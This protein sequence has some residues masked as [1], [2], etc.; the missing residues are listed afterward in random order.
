MCGVGRD[1]SLSGFREPAE[2][3]LNADASRGR[4]NGTHARGKKRIEFLGTQRQ[5][6]GHLAY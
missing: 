2:A 4:N 6:R 1:N 5:K 3:G